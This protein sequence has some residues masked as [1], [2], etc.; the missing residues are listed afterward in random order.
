VTCEA[1]EKTPIF[2]GKLDVKVDLDIEGTV[3]Y[4]FAV[5]GKLVPPK[6]E[7]VGYYAYA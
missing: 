4:G 5:E 7:D 6:L 3:S 2:N 1:T